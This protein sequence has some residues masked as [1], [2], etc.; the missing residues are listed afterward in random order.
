M[1]IQFKKISNLPDLINSECGIFE[2]VEGTFFTNSRRY[3]FQT[4]MYL[5]GWIQERRRKIYARVNPKALELYFQGRIT[6]KELFLLRI[7]EPFILEP[8]SSRGKR[9]ERQE[10]I[11]ADQEFLDLVLS[12]LQCGEDYYHQHSEGMRIEN[13]MD[14]VLP[15]LKAQFAYNGL[16]KQV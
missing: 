10:K 13:P 16:R 9:G 14:K 15:V 4:A 12:T 3:E 7:D 6:L 8:S 5:K 2:I 11:F 1:K